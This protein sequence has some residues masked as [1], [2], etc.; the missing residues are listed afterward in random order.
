MFKPT[1]LYIKT[2]NNTGLKYFGKTVNKHPATYRGSGVRWLN[3]LNYHGNDVTTEIIGYYINEAE[4]VAAAIAFS[5][6]NNIVESSEWANLEIENGVD[7]GFV[8]C[9]GDKN[10][11][12]GTMWITDGTH[13]RKIPKSELVPPGWTRGRVVPQDWGVNL[14]KKLK[15]RTHAE[16]LGE[17]K[18]SMLAESKRQRMLGNKFA[19]K[20]ER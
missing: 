12:F 19:A 15:G 5:V 1:Y 9:I 4:C 16:M 14:S 13:N 10:T 18:A 2:H 6:T 8:G 20:D 7:G 17:E 11:Q 3:H